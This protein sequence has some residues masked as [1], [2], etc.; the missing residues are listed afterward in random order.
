MFLSFSS[1]AFFFPFRTTLSF[2]M[3]MIAFFPFSSMGIIICSKT[4]RDIVLRLRK[5]WMFDE[6]KEVGEGRYLSSWCRR[7]CE[8]LYM[9]CHGRLD[10]YGPVEG[11]PNAEIRCNFLTLPCIAEKCLTPVRL[12]IRCHS[13]FH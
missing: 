4:G 3:V 5:R 6:A 11:V 2:F 10:I 13:I 1:I 9:K 12:Y 7:K 8:K